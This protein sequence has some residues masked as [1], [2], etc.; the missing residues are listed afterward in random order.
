M[1]GRHVLRSHSSHPEIRIQEINDDAEQSSQTME[2]PRSRRQ[3]TTSETPE[4][5]T[6]VAPVAP[7]AGGINADDIFKNSV[8]FQAM[9]ETIQALKDNAARSTPNP[10]VTKKLK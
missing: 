3:S 1:A 6:P 2:T 4:R 10:P 8:L 7:M 9:Q 5:A